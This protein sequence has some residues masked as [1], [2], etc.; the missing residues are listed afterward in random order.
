M[1]RTEE[2][3][4][5]DSKKLHVY[6]FV[7]PDCSLVEVLHTRVGPRRAT[8]F[9]SA[10]DLPLWLQE[11]IAVLWLL[12]GNGDVGGVGSCTSEGIGRYCLEGTTYDDFIKENDTG[13]GRDAG[14]DCRSFIIEMGDN[15]L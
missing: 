2:V 8:V 10:D 1:S 13:K 5:E 9:D 12:D 4:K 6:V 7:D 14:Y 15:K 3:P 11:R